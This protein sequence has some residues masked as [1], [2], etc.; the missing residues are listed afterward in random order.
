[1]WI[2]DSYSGEMSWDTKNDRCKDVPNKKVIVTFIVRKYD[3][4]L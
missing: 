1:M 3:K 4:I 2:W